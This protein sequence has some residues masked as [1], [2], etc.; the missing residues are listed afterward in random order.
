VKLAQS[1]WL[2][3]SFVISFA[4]NY[5]LV[6]RVEEGAYAA[7]STLASGEA[8]VAGARDGF[9]LL[10]LRVVVT[11]AS[12][13]IGHSVPVQILV[14]RA[15]LDEGQSEPDLE[16]FVDLTPPEGGVLDASG[17][18]IDAIRRR[19]LAV[20]PKAPGSSAS[21]R[22][23]LP[24]APSA[25]AITRGTLTLTD[26]IEVSP[27]TYRVRGELDVELRDEGDRTHALMARVVA[28]LGW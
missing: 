5:V 21:S 3:A 18:N 9:K 16:L 8:L 20:L 2:L 17:R 12:S 19:P 26:A 22:V 27:Q 6:P 7:G 11:E 15:A 4:T 24:G 10:D 25:A 28:K 14:M 23:R 13:P 1:V